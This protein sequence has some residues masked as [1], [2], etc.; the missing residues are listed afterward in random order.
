MV[1]NCFSEKNHIRKSLVIN[2]KGVE[3]CFIVF[4]S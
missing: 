2:K 3:Y 1:L 4:F